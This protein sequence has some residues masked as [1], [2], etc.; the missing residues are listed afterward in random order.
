L[1]YNPQQE[2]RDN[3]GKGD[4]C[5][6]DTDVDGI[7]DFMDNCPNNS[8]IFSTD[9]RTYQVCHLKQQWEKMT[10]SSNF[11]RSIKNLCVIYRSKRG[12]FIL[13]NL[14]NCFPICQED[15]YKFFFVSRLLFSIPTATLR[16]IR[17][18]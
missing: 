13:F 17:T 10:N 6:D 14:K 18:G 2:D 5:Q 3:D 1:A 4:V 11:V 15:H 7:L 9:F 12:F 16:S 8:K